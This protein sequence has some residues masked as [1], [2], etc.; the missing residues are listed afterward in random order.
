MLINSDGPLDHVN[1]AILVRR[2]LSCLRFDSVPAATPEL[3]RFSSSIDGRRGRFDLTAGN[4]YILR[5]FSRP[6]A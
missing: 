6:L 1:P 2:R 4:R 5:S 3:R